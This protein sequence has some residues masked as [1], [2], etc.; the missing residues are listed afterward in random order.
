MLLEQRLVQRG[1]GEGGGARGGAVVGVVGARGRERDGLTL[2]HPGVSSRWPRHDVARNL[3][4]RSSLQNHGR[5]VV[6]VVDGG[7]VAA[8]RSRTSTVVVRLLRQRHVTELGVEGVR[9][10]VLLVRTDGQELR[11]RKRRRRKRIR[12]HWVVDRLRGRLERRTDRLRVKVIGRLLL[13]CGRD[14]LLWGLPVLWDP[15]GSGGDAGR[16]INHSAAIGVD[17]RLACVRVDQNAARWY[18]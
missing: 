13:G 17:E 6:V 15:A 7:V 14:W 12:D 18:P 5:R 4:R 9:H 11:R 2:Q 8:V 16:V 10:S 3:L 1:S